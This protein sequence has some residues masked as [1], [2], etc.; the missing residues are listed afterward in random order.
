MLGMKIEHGKALVD[1]NI[2]DQNLFSGLD[3]SKT[4]AIVRNNQSSQNN[5]GIYVFGGGS[6]EIKEN[7]VFKNK[8]NGIEVRT[9]A[10]FKSISGNTVKNNENNGTN[11][12]YHVWKYC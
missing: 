4:D 2:L 9:P 10:K 7:E 12:N 3:L 1:E 5:V 11:L 6:V 8:L